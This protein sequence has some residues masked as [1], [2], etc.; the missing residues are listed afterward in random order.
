M[1]E[2]RKLHA[3]A[4]QSFDL[5][6]MPDDFSR[7]LW[8]MLPLGLDREGRGIDNPAWIKAK[9]MPLRTDVSLEQVAAALDWY[10]A[11]GMLVRYAVGGHGYFYIPTF[12][13]YQGNTTREAPSVIPEPPQEVDVSDSRPTQDLL[14]SLSSTDSDSDA[15]ADV[16]SEQ[17]FAAG[18]AAGGPEQAPLA[19]QAAEPS[20]E[21]D[22]TPQP[23]PRTAGPGPPQLSP[24]QGQLM[25][26]W[27]VKRA[28]ASQL[29]LI[30]ELAGKY[31]DGLVAEAA[32]WAL[33]EGM[34]FGHAL[35]SIKAA[36][37]KWNQRRGRNGANRTDAGRPGGQAQ[38]QIGISD[39][40]R[41]KLAE[42]NSRD[43]SP[44]GP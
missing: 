38:R 4:T 1:P 8:V 11:R 39:E 12:G 7:L 30:G 40:R 35:N 20:G 21:P 10:A 33:V 15:D 3:K 25:A 17:P 6:E 32:Q 27:K 2:W 37:P 43:H 16:D 41:A 18:A 14:A 31:G 23:H 42:A 5:N 34:A 22:A 19:G 13:H 26:L 44:R 24:I 9:V 36:L 28:N 29:A